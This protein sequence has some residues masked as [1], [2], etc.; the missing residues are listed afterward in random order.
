MVMGGDE[1]GS[2]DGVSVGE[3]EVTVV[4]SAGVL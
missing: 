3:W 2:V 4:V 1:R